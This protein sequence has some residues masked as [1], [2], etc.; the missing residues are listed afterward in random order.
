MSQ[1]NY[2]GD[3]GCAVVIL[4][5]CL[6]VQCSKLDRIETEVQQIRKSQK[7]EGQPTLAPPEALP[8]PEEL[9]TP[10]PEPKGKPEPAIE[11]K[12]QPDSA[13]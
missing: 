1:C 5:V 4:F 3:S 12:Q 13:V 10:G 7:T 8:E 9:F 6:F 11:I 2:S